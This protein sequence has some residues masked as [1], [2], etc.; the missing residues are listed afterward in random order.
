MKGKRCQTLSQE[1]YFEG[2]NLRRMI[3]CVLTV[4]QSVLMDQYHLME[5]VIG[6]QIGQTIQNQ[7]EKFIFIFI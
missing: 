1:V 3:G 2:N 4:L 7:S 5:T 6:K